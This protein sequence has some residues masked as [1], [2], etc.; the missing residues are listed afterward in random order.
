MALDSNFNHSIP[1][2]P[3]RDMPPDASKFHAH[4]NES[5]AHASAHRNPKS[6]YD[7]KHVN[8]D[9]TGSA[10]ARLEARILSMCMIVQP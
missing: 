9:P 6:I 8:W 7:V 5:I 1:P 3:S 10:S 2:T 4:V